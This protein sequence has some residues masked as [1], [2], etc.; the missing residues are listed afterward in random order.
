MANTIGAASPKNGPNGMGADIF[1]FVRILSGTIV[2][3]AIAEPII[4]AIKA[5]SAPIIAPKPAKSFTSPKPIPSFFIIFALTTEN[6]YKPPPQAAKPI[7]ELLQPMPP[8]KKD[9]A[10]PTK[11]P[12]IVTVS[13]RSKYL[14]SIAKIGISVTISQNMAMPSARFAAFA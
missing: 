7:R 8:S 13:G 12:P 5:S 10:N 14:K 3:I 2:I 11:I 1:S 6:K 9:K 4:K